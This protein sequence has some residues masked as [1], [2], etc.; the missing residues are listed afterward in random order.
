MMSSTSKI[1]F[2]IDDLLKDQRPTSAPYYTINDK[3][4]DRDWHH[5]PQ[6]S[7]RLSLFSQQIDHFNPLNFHRYRLPAPYTDVPNAFNQSKF[8]TRN[9]HFIRQE[10]CHGRC[11]KQ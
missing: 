9:V 5:Y 2:A 3:T 4:I 11:T 6:N 7:N 8:S 10:K 1:S